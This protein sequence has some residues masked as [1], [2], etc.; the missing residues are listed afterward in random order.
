MSLVPRRFSHF[1]YAALQSGLT[2]A[3]AAAI[4]SE[5]LAGSGHFLRHWGQSWIVSWVV[6]LPVVLLAAPVIQHLTL[7]LTREA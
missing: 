1:V 7:R 4:A 3:V 5:P 2:C 6:M